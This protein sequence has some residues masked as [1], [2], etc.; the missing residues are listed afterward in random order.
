MMYF[1]DDDTPDLPPTREEIVD[2]AN[3]KLGYAVADLQARLEIAR[4]ESIYGVN[5][6]ENFFNGNWDRLKDLEESSGLKF[7]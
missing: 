5:A 7:T 2:E 3:R 1:H 6:M 4:L